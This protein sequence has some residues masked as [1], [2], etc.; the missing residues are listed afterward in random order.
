[1]RIEA[2]QY[3]FGV[4]WP[5]ITQGEFAFVMDLRPESEVRAYPW[6]LGWWVAVLGL[7]DWEPKPDLAPFVSGL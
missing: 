2:P 7:L 3:E 4:H 1:M 5:L 6:F